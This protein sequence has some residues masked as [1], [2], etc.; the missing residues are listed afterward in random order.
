MTIEAAL[1]RESGQLET[2]TRINLRDMLDNFGLSGLRTG[3]GL[4]ESLFWP[5]AERFARQVIHF[6]ERVG[7]AGLRQAS[8]EM[9]QPYIRALDVAGA[10]AI[11]PSGPVVFASNHPGMVDTLACFSSIPRDDLRAVSADRPFTRALP[12]I[13]RRLIHV[14]E[15]ASERLLAVR[16]VVRHLRQGGA[17]L[18]CPA[19]RI[20]PDPVCMPGAADALA[21]WSDSLGLFIR[22]EPRAAVVPT[23]VSGVILPSTLRSPLTRVRR[24]QR[25]RERVAATLQLLLQTLAPRRHGLRVRVEFGAPLAGADLAALGDAAA[26]ARAVTGRVKEMIDRLHTYG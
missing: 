23:V 11:P 13:D 14:S 8:A 5:P 21:G 2:L 18:I 22:Q 4:L 20:E 16:Q 19:G 3:R 10:G 9:L 12:N 26:V 24:T 7:A 15:Q 1:A 17:V 25:D 6:D